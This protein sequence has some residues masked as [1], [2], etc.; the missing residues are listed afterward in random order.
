MT[1][2]DNHSLPRVQQS[3]I[4]TTMRKH[5][6]TPSRADNP[7]HAPSAAAAAPTPWTQLLLRQLSL[8]PPGADKMSDAERIT[9][10]LSLA[11]IYKAHAQDCG[12]HYNRGF[13]EATQTKHRQMEVLRAEFDEKLASQQ[14]EIE[15][16]R[17]QQVPH[18][19]VFGRDESQLSHSAHPK[20][21]QGGAV[22]DV[23]V[24]SSGRVQPTPR[25][26]NP[27]RSPSATCALIARSLQIQRHISGR[28][29]S[30]DGVAKLRAL[31]NTS[32]RLSHIAG[33]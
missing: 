15:A 26:P 23:A 27:R 14:Q 19:G 32:M 28:H 25:L 13:L 4:G 31:S 2:F 22:M 9:L 21:E 33:S 6:G 16:L 24:S 30:L 1:G 18:V 3:P 29:S 11:Y 5:M 17:R 7:L 12:F 10:E 20:Q 8:A